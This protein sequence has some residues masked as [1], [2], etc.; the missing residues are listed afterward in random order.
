MQKLLL[1]SLLLTLCTDYAFAQCGVNEIEVRVEITTDVYGNETYWTLTDII[2]TVVMQGGQGGIYQNSSTY[3]DSLCVPADGCFFFEI[4][5]TY[6]DGI[7]APNGYKLY[8]NE[9]LVSSGADDIKSYAAVIASCPNACNMTLNALNDLN[10]HIN[11]TITLSAN[12]LTQNRNTF[13][14]FSYCLAE[15]ES[16][17]VL[18]KSVVENY[19]NQ[20]G[21]LFTTPNTEYGFSK[22]P[23][24]APGLEVERAML[25]FSKEYST[26]Y[27]PRNVYAD[28]P[29]HINGW[30]F[31]SC[32][33]F[34][35]YVDP[36]ADS[37]VSNSVL[38]RANFEDPDGMNP[39]YDINFERMEHALRPTG[40]YLSPE[41]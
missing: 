27:S 4:Y 14:K 36:P 21:V 20:I 39:Y 41:V 28:Y 24:A 40:L 37:S 31:N 38:I 17:I 16:M 33:A 5:D 13:V 23:A 22:N 9:I 7:F 32:S 8:V 19:D 30:N 10:V 26:I 3:K 34:P 6:G 29:Q 2:G 25:A 15:N 12:E 35:G 11:G 18:A 1:I